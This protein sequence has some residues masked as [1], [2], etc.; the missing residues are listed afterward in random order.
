MSRENAHTH[1]NNRR[2]GIVAKKLQENKWEVPR[3]GK[4]TNLIT[5]G[6][7]LYMSVM[8]TAK[9]SC[10]K[11][12]RMIKPVMTHMCCVS[13]SDSDQDHIH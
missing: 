7:K 13:D 1:R 11:K 6:R 9:D 12:T 2:E 3:I 8:T 10:G 5:R 4:D